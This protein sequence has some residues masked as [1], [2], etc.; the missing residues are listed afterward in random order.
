[1]AEKYTLGD[2]I[3]KEM[4]KKNI[5]YARLEELSGV[6][7]SALQR[8]VSGGTAK[9]PSDR[10][11]KIAG[12]LS[13]PAEVLLYKSM[14]DEQQRGSEFSGLAHKLWDDNN[15]PADPSRDIY[16]F[17]PVARVPVLG[18]IAAGAPLLAQEHILG[19][20]A[21]EMGDFQNYFYLRVR[22]DSMINAGINDGDMVLIRIQDTAENGQIVACRLNGDEATLK[23]F[24]RQGSSVMLIPENPDYDPRIVPSA[25]FEQG[26]ASIIGVAVEVKRRL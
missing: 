13:M 25:D 22:G 18:E 26:Q 5:S 23:R 17:E 11:I 12:A 10:L 21:V 7:K 15:L 4:D 6:P 2:V 16:P 8:Y 19:Y 20:E 1:M 3:R 24:R 14:F 9:I